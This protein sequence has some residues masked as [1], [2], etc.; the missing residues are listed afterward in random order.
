MEGRLMVPDFGG[1]LK[2][3]DH[4]VAD[5]HCAKTGQVFATGAQLIRP[6]QGLP[7]PRRGFDSGNRVLLVTS[8]PGQGCWLLVPHF[9]VPIHRAT[10]TLPQLQ[11]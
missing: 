8:A 11:L 7:A 1:T 5:N 3:R 2:P 10:L 4:M 9:D 6:A